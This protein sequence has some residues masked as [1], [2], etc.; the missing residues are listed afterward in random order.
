MNTE[1]RWDLMVRRNDDVWER[2][3]RIIGPN[4]TGVDMRAQIRFA[5][6]TPGPPMANLQLVTNGNAEG[7][8]LAGATQQADGTWSNDVRIRLNKSTRQA[9]PYAGEVGAT[10]E[11]EWGL[12]IAGIT[13]LEGKVYVPAQVY[14]SDSAPTIRP[15]SFGARPV[16]ASVGSS[17]ATLTI[18]QD[19]GAALVIDGADLLG[20]MAAQA[21]AAKDVTVTKAAEVS[22]S[23]VATQVARDQAADLVRPQNIFA[24]GTLAAAEAAVASGTTFK[25]VHDGLAEVR[26]RTA[27]GSDVLYQEVTAARLTAAISGVGQGKYMIRADEWGLVKGVAGNPPYSQKQYED[28]YNNGVRLQAALEYARDKGFPGALLEPGDYALTPNNLSGTNTLNN[29]SLLGCVKLSGFGRFE[30][31]LNGSKF[32]TVFDSAVRSPYDKGTGYL[33][34]QLRMNHFVLSNNRGLRIINATLEGERLKRA[35]TNANE[36]AEEQSY[37]FRIGSGNKDIS[38]SGIYGGY[39]MGD[40]YQG[41][42]SIDAVSVYYG[43]LPFYAGGV[44]TAGEEIVQAGAYRTAKHIISGYNAERVYLYLVGNIQTPRF[45]EPLLSA[46]F[47]NEVGGFVGKQN[48]Y[49]SQGVVLP[50]NAHTVQFVAYGDERTDPQVSYLAG[51]SA[52]TI[53]L[54]MTEGVTVE[55]FETY[56]NHRGGISNMP[57]GTLIRRGKFRHCGSVFNLPGVPQFPYTTRY[58]INNEDTY[59]D[60]IDIEDVESFGSFNHVLLAA[61]DWSIKNYRAQGGDPGGSGVALVIATTMTGKV[62]DFYGADLRVLVQPTFK[63]FQNRRNISFKG[64]SA[65]RVESIFSSSDVDVA[66]DNITASGVSAQDSGFGPAIGIAVSGAKLKGRPIDG[67]GRIMRLTDYSGVEMELDLSAASDAPRFFIDSR[68]SKNSIDL[69]LRGGELGEQSTFVTDYYKRRIDGLRIRY[70][71][72]PRRLMFA[73]RSVVPVDLSTVESWY[74]NEC[75]FDDMSFLEFTVTRIGATTLETQITFERTKFGKNS[76]Y[77][78]IGAGSTTVDDKTVTIIFKDCE[79]DMTSK[80]GPFNWIYI[81]GGRKVVIRFINCLFRADAAKAAP[82]V[83]GAKANLDSKLMG[84]QFLNFTNNDGVTT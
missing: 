4:L 23:L 33:P 70:T 2:P 46:F 7:I 14:G 24:T 13:R 56:S 49:F 61:R 34:Y 81:I 63:A 80:T 5:G 55:N 21:Q 43:D 19:G 60:R 18:S 68:N 9:F 22:A 52:F 82:I 76:G 42:A 15:Q 51:N 25:W 29:I 50:K 3:L 36:R 44:G 79:I 35:Y 77:L 73:R 32:T 75:D 1:T 30:L 20:P 84:C 45:R 59:S 12:L 72:Q 47:H 37:G 58:S 78:L 6:D 65:D 62:T 38:F 69:R 71:D 57:N 66:G 16:A 53:R 28:A 74:F 67:S 54:D 41:N 11:L 8:R 17:G 39:F 48:F 40:L 10:Q 31:D 83:A 27:V 64:V 26:K